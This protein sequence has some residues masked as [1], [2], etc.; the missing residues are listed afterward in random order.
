MWIDVDSGN[1]PDN[2]ARVFVKVG[3][4]NAVGVAEYSNHSGFEAEDSAYDI[5]CDDDSG[6]RVALNGDV[7]AWMLI[8]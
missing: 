2:G 5:Y 3:D 1:L 8:P 7:R 6:M 4:E